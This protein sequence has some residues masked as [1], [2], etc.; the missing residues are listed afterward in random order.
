MFTCY[1][2][3]AFASW[4]CNSFFL[5]RCDSAEWSGSCPNFFLE[6]LVKLHITS[7]EYIQARLEMNKKSTYLTNPNSL[8]KHPLKTQAKMSARPKNALRI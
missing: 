6:K 4:C 5:F 8:Q 7:H 3:V 2:L 1:C